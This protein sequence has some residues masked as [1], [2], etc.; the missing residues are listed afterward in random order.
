MSTD[1]RTAHFLKAFPENIP[2]TDGVYQILDSSA[3]GRIRNCR[4]SLTDMQWYDAD[5][6]VKYP[7]FTGIVWYFAGPLLED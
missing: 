7:V 4:W 6:V 1:D 2:S 3:T 5:E